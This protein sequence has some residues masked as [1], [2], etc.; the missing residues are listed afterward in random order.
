MRFRIILLLSALCVVLLTALA[1][2]LARD[3]ELQNLK[4]QA[5]E[6][7]S[8]KRNSILG[9]TAQYRFLPF[10][11]GTDERIKELLREPSVRAHIEVADLKPEEIKEQ[12][13]EL[14]SEPRVRAQVDVANRHLEAINDEAQSMYLYVLNMDGLCV[15]SSNWKDATSFVGSNYSDR[16]YYKEAIGSVAGEGYFYAVGKN[17]GLPGFHWARRIEDEAGNAGVAV[18]KLDLTKLRTTWAAA[19]ER[20]SVVD[21]AGMIFLSST[22]E[23][24]FRPLTPI[25]QADIERILY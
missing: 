17:T 7:L 5:D 14:L 6:S 16:R 13:K 1:W 12:I 24:E 15:A 21:Q 25:S 4:V 3:L 11:L 10:I 19:G 18:V 2:E 8:L 22:D 9:E 23:W 20:V